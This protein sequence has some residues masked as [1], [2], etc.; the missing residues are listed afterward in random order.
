MTEM[1]QVRFP[2]T[3]PEK[4]LELRIYVWKTDERGPGS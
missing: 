3:G 2:E 1:R 4:V